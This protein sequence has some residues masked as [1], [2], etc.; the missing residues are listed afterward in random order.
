MREF[1]Q[2]KKLDILAALALF[3]AFALLLLMPQKY[4]L[5]VSAPLSAA[6]AAASCI[7][8][9]K[10]SIHSY[11]KRQV[12]IIVLVFILLYLTLFYLSGLSFGY[13]LSPKG[14]I[15]LSSLIRFILPILIIIFASEKIRELTLAQ[16]IRAAI[17]LS[18]ATGVLADVVC[19]GGIPSIR[20]SLQFADFFGMTLFPALTANILFTYLSKRYGKNPCI[21]YRAFLSLY[22]YIIP[23]IPDPPRALPS[24]VLL[25][26]PL[27]I[28]SFIDTLFEKRRRF[29]RK[30]KSKLGFIFSGI[31]L[32][33]MLGFVLLIT[34]QFRFGMVVIAT[35]SMSGEIN[36]GD[37]VVYESYEHSGQIK[38]NDIIVFSENNKRVVHRVVAINYVNGQKQYITKGDANEGIDTGYRTDA[39]IIGV[40]RFKVLYIGH[41][42]LWL[43]EIIRK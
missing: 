36:R 13:Y 15:S 12:L 3:A 16:P 41:P 21:L 25:L 11:N 4:I 7:V 37:A 27:I 14:R 5:L 43:R 42:S 6:L 39:N 28:Y 38:E 26:L 19:A 35:E 17:P 20:S 8:M 31:A 1:S 34:C 2:D 33:M 10:R 30:K 22:P 9:K 24:F 23:W 29:A 18:F 32:F 40:V